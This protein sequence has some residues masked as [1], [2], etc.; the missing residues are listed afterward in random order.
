MNDFVGTLEGNGA[1][2]SVRALSKV[3]SG[4]GALKSYSSNFAST[5]GALSE[6]EIEAGSPLNAIF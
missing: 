1:Q 3:G 2:K 5:I 6:E 4:R